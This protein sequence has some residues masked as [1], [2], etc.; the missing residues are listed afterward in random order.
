MIQ[1]GILNPYILSLLARIR[2]TNTLVIA[3]WAFPSWPGIETVDISLVR[4]VPTIIDVL[5]AMAPNFKVGTIWQASE[6]LTTNEQSV[7]D[8][9]DLAM[10]GFTVAK[11]ERLPHAELKKLVPGSTGLIRTGD[12]TSYG[13]LILQSV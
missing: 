4:G 3:D 2:H 7:I 10:A 13:N 11:V 12:T 9:F 6:F 5:D 1:S 8:R